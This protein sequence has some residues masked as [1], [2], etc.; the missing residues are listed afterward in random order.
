MVVR[1]TPRPRVT[2]I[3]AYKPQLAQLVK[4]PPEGSEWLHE[5]KYDGYRIGCRIENGHRGAQG[6]RVIA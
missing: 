5:I 4:T 1:K 3:P 2:A 6:N